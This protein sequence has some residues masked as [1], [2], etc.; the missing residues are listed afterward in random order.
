[1]TR[2]IRPRSRQSPLRF[3]GLSRCQSSRSIPPMIG[4]SEGQ[5]MSNR[6]NQTLSANT[7]RLNLGSRSLA[8]V[9][10]GNGTTTLRFRLAHLSHPGVVA[11]VER[12]RWEP[13]I[14]M[15]AYRPDTPDSKRGACEVD[16]SRSP[17]F[18]S[19]SWLFTRTERRMFAE[20]PPVLKPVV[21]IDVPGGRSVPQPSQPSPHAPSRPSASARA[22]GAACRASDRARISDALAS[23]AAS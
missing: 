13:S 18:L 8:L 11:R 19:S 9:A 4:G 20:A 21:V 7:N 10:S 2:A 3:S 23:A 17:S 15:P 6:T 22:T 1:M 5:V 12:M 14:S 16:G